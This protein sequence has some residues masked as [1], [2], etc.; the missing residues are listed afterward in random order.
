MGSNFNLCIEC[1]SWVHTKCSGIQKCLCKTVN[2]VCRKYTDGIIG[3]KIFQELKKVIFNFDGSRLPLMLNALSKMAVPYPRLFSH[4]AKNCCPIADKT[5]KYSKEDADF[6]RAET[7]RLVLEDIIEP[8]NSPRRAQLLV[9]KN[10][11][12]G[13]RH[14][15]I[16]YNRII[17]LFTQLDAYPISQIEEIVSE[18]SRYK[19]FT[20]IDLKSVYHQ[21]ELVPR[22]RE[23]TAFQSG[24]ELYQWQRLP[25]GLRNAIPEFQ[26][27]INHF[28]EQN[29]LK[30]CFP[31]LD[32]ITIAGVYQSEHDINLKAFL[33][34][35]SATKITINESKTQLSQTEI[36]LLG[37]K[38]GFGYIKPD[39][40]RIQPLFD[41][42]L[43]Q[44]NRKL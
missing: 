1:N 5:R 44:S 12:S 43:P 27:A 6:I 10:E 36:S 23:Y 3:E 28:I 15:V 17:N 25:F 39:P 9:A 13:K 11:Q 20:T 14:M 31:Y 32:N 7:Q 34:A 37:Y 21:I 19:V 42:S 4:L 24:N 41:L 18:L 16:D 38:V 40:E 35:A 2:F 8:S 22:D 30:G 29:S 33:D 26:R